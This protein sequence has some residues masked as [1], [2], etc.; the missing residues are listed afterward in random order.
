MG[1]PS[2]CSPVTDCFTP[3]SEASRVTVRLFT[4]MGAGLYRDFS[5]LS[6]QVPR[7]LSAPKAQMAVNAKAI[8]VL[9]RVFMCQAPSG[10]YTLPDALIPLLFVHHVRQRLAGA[11]AVKLFEEEA[12]GLLLPIGGVIGTVR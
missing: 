5:I 11:E 6:F 12:H 1:V 2:A 4:G 9:L 7:V 10:D 3:P 8:N